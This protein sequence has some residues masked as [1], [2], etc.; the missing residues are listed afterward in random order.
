[1]GMRTIVVALMTVL[2]LWGTQTQAATDQKG[3]LVVALDT[4]GAQTM[5]PILEARAPHA[6]YQAPVYDCIVWFD[7]VKGGIGPGAAERWEMA[8]DGKSWIFYVRQGQRW[9]NGD[10]VTAHDIKFSLERTISPESLVSRAAGLRRDIERIEV[11]DDYT[12][13]IYTNGTLPYFP[14]GL[15]RAVFQEGQLMPNWLAEASV[16]YHT[17]KFE[18]TP[19]VNL[20]SGI[21]RSGEVP[22]RH[23]GF[24]FFQ[25]SESTNMQY[26]V[27]FSTDNS[28]KRSRP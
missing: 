28:S 12:V 26:Q 14:E 16:A 15:S 6:H 23:G 9:H 2:L 3:T 5:D 8:P 24:G 1:M 11:Q 19:N 22:T 4:L 18:E 7:P 21:D 25:N 17:D 13:R 20:H 10:P 27:K